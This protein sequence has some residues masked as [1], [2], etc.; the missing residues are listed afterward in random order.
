M[1]YFWGTD[2]EHFPPACPKTCWSC[3]ISF[4]KISFDFEIQI[5][6]E[7]AFRAIFEGKMSEQKKE[8]HLCKTADCL[9]VSGMRWTSYDLPVKSRDDH[10]VN[11]PFH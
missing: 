5:K 1:K 10:D 2:Y 9:R 4:T 6:F 11:Q 3:Y 7:I 8:R